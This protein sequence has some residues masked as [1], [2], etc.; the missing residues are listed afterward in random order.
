MIQGMAPPED[1]EKWI[2]ALLFI[3]R[4]PERRTR[5]WS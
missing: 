5:R 2:C 4:L 3:R 1:R